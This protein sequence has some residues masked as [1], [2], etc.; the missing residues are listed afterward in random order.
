M[1]ESLINKYF[2]SKNLHGALIISKKNKTLFFHIAKTGG[3]SIAKMLRDNGFDDDVI[4]NRNLPVHIKK[5]YFEEVARNWNKYFKFTFVRNKFTQLKSLYNM[6]CSINY[7]NRKLNIDSPTFE[8]FILTFIDN[9]NYAN[10]PSWMDQYELLHLHDECIF[11]FIGYFE[12]YEKDLN[13][14]KSK[15][16]IQN[17]EYRENVGNYNKSKNLEFTDIMIQKVRNT[18]PKEIEKFNWII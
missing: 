9:E 18:Y 8:S 7:F 10:N 15:F 11:D 1:E 12:N 16:N 4:S 3:S 13:F 14:I 5:Q 2:D 6:D 17:K